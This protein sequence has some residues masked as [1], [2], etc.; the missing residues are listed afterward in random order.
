MMK[1]ENPY[2]FK[3]GKRDEKSMSRD[4]RLSSNNIY[5]EQ[6]KKVIPGM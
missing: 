3:N 5:I 1:N 4:A 2:L 6:K